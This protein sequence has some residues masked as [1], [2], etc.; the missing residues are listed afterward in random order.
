[1]S[2]RSTFAKVI[3]RSYHK[4]KIKKK[5]GSGG[6]AQVAERLLNKF[7]ALESIHS[8]RKQNSFLIIL[9]GLGFELITLPLDR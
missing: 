8:T 5:R 4:V 3:K 9:V 7:K 6:V 1:M 2:S